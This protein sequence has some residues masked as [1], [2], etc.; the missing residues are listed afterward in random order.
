M[1]KTITSKRVKTMK[2]EQL[3][4]LAQ[5]NGYAKKG[6]CD[7]KSKLDWFIKGRINIR[8]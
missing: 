5:S 6:E 4:S 2:K 8:D 7:G 3:S 1:N